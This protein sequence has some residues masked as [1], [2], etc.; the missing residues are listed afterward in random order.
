M[1]GGEGRAVHVPRGHR[2]EIVNTGGA[3][4]VD[5]WALVLPDA[6]RHMSMSH[7]RT[8]MNRV[9]PRLGDT[10]VDDA[11]QPILHLAEDTSAG[12]H[13]TLLAACDPARYAGLG[14]EGWHASCSDNFRKAVV[15]AGLSLVDAP[16]PLNLFQ[17]VDIAGDGTLDLGSSPANPGSKVVFEALQ[18][19][20]VVVSACPMDLIAISG[21]EAPRS[22]ELVVRGTDP[23]SS[24][25]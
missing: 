2:V 15:A 25:R 12:R 10:L 24:A 6:T 13:D 22:V 23:V 16:D 19:A 5:T 21:S 14:H 11:R 8:A 4:V 1:P 9:S 20:L 18:D 7:S 3:Q 17:A